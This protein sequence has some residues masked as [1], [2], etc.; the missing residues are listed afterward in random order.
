MVFFIKLKTNFILVVVHV[1]Y[2]TG[3]SYGR[4]ALFKQQTKFQDV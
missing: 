3:T 2:F 4:D 1:I